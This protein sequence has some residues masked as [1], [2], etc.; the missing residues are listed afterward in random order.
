MKAATYTCEYPPRILPQ[1]SASIPCCLPLPDPL[2][3]FIAITFAD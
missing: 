2:P 3:C 1:L